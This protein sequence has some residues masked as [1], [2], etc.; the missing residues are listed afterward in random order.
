MM[1]LRLAWPFLAALLSAPPHVPA[2]GGPPV[3][4]LVGSDAKIQLMSGRRELFEIHAGLYDRNWGG[5]SAVGD[6][7]SIVPGTGL[8]RFT[9]QPPSGA[10]L[11]GTAA[12]TEN[13]KGA[14]KAEYAFTPGGDAPLQCVHVNA[15]FSVAVLAGG[16]WTADGES[17]TFPEEFK[18]IGLFS[19]PIRA[20]RLEL[21]T[22]EAFDFAFPD[23]TPVLLQ[24]N[25]KWGP[26]FSVRIHRNAPG[27]V[28][29]GGEPVRIAFT[30][31]A[32]DG[33]AVAFD[34]PVVLAAG[35]EWIPLT[36]ELD[37]EAGS[38]LDFSGQGFA[39]APAGKHGW[40]RASPA[41]HFF[42]EN[43]P[44]KAPRRF[45][46]V[47][48]CFSAQFIT[49]EQSDRLADRLAR[50]GYNAVRIHH[51]EGELCQ[52]Q[53]NSYDLN[54][55]KVEQ[56]DYMM[57]AFFKRGLY[58]T[59]DLFVSRP[60]P[61]AEIGQPGGG[62]VGMDEFKDLVPVHEKAFENF[63]AFARNLLTHV[64]PHTGRSYAQE[65]GLA[66]IALI[67]EG[68]LG[69]FY[70]TLRNVPEWVAAWNRW[71]VGRYPDRSALARAWGADLKESEDPAKGNV[72]MAPGLDGRSA[73]NR[74]AVSFLS[75]VEK[76]FFQRASAFLRK[77][78]GV[79]ALLTNMS[80]WTNHATD[81]LAR[82]TFDYVDDHFYVDHPQFLERPW[83]LPSRCPNTSPV[84]TGATGGR[85]CSFTRLLGKPFTITEYNYSAPG[86]F[87]GVGGIL[88]GA[89]G[90][91][92]DW[93]GIWRFCYSHSRESSFK[94]S[95]MNYFDM[96][97]D[98]LGQAAERASL[99]L[100]ARRDLEEKGMPHLVLSFREEKLAAMDQPVPRLSPAWHWTAW[101]AGV[102]THLRKG[103]P[104]DAPWAAALAGSGGATPAADALPSLTLV[105]PQDGYAV[106]N[107]DL[108]KALR[109]LL[110]E[111]NLTDPAKNVFQSKGGGI[112]IDAPRDT[113][114]LDTPRT[115]GG[116]APAGQKIAAANGVEVSVQEADATVWASSLD[117][118]PIR[119][120]RRVLVTHLTDCQNTDIRYAERARK[121]LQAWGR[122]PHLVRAGKAEVRLKLQNAAGMKVYALSTS[123]RR[124]GE[125]PSR[126]EAGS[127]VFTADVAG[128]AAG[129]TAVLCYEVAAP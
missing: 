123:G 88:T 7:K 95:P 43:D 58:A 111:K 48:L 35:P 11:P 96:A 109:P 23:P 69:N 39:D 115:A 82:A 77:E 28:F 42:F 114:I 59:T 128:A 24:D 102:S 3:E 87:R 126:V 100:F 5:A 6:A 98:P 104:A 40:V 67:N 78:L 110:G 51:Y 33:L 53:K 47:N 12:F 46:G 18:D 61:R 1:N 74:D 127:L 86:R 70:G 99:C 94:P 13:P 120:S 108:M 45:Y 117:R 38:A 10:A 20:L 31:T 17:G 50:L 25:R 101:V 118:K 4:A 71:L 89:L 90:A 15:E 36:L 22:G 73:R 97:T 65:P 21:P 84:S 113:M 55:E 41:G 30:L 83:R 29:K 27:G 52:G 54:P 68:N 57:A 32:K 49:H 76:D 124:L 107:D 106:K 92:Q 122:L 66:W 81:Q 64:N 91:I 9:L 80:C 14:L 34:E 75:H 8:R 72:P 119:E 121:T 112:L 79:K 44:Q 62:N 16:R 2:A 60:V 129:Q 56:F 105:A 63:K 116:Y 103:A 85:H 93:D 37:V 19:K 125:V 26:S